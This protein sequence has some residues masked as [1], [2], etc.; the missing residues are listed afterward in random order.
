MQIHE[1]ITYGEIYDSSDNLWNFMLFT[2]YFRKISEWMEG[3]AIYAELTIPNREVQYIFEEKVQNW[4]RE[5]IKG[6]NMAPLYTAFVN[7]DCAALEE[8]INDI[9]EETISYMDQNEYYYHGMVTGLLTGIKGFGLRSNREGG[10][11]RSDLFVRPVHR[12]REAFVIEFKVAKDIDD[13]EAKADEAL[14]QIAEKKYDVELRN[15]GYKYVSCY[16]IAFCGKECVVHCN[17]LKSVQ[18]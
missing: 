11:G 12:S 9:F 2:G 13:M 17:A 1:D 5:K 18:G 10:R 6:R 7:K 16:G 15:D 14:R 8:Q 3:S 4:F